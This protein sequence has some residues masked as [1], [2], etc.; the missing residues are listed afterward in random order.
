MAEFKIEWTEETWYRLYIE[1]DS[2]E[3]AQDKFWS[4]EFDYQKAKIT[5]SEIQDSVEI[6]EA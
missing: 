6:E 5:G 2:F 3:D 4:G 1:A